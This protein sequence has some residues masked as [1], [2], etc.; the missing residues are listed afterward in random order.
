MAKASGDEVPGHV[1]GRGGGGRSEECCECP[2]V[3]E[4]RIEV[5][6][7]GCSHVAL[8]GGTAVGREVG[9]GVEASEEIRHERRRGNGA[10]DTARTA[11]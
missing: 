4:G 8:D 11:A 10:L 2:C 6:V 1:E 5:R 9:V 3:S 7:V